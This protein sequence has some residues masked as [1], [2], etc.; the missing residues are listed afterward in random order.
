MLRFAKGEVRIKGKGGY[1]A[2]VVE[3]NRAV[4]RAVKVG[5]TDDND[6]EILEGIKAGERIISKGIEFI[7]DGAL[8]SIE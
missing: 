7:R 8:V 3:N 2:Y 6:I 5:I 1:L 4:K